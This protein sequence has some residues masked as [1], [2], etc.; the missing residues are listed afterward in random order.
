MAADEALAIVMKGYPRLSETFIA[1]ELL[2]LQ[3]SGLPFTIYALRKPTDA[4]VHAV[5]EAIKAPVRYLPEYLYQAPHRVISAWLQIRR[6]PELSDGYRRAWQAWLK[7][8]RRD[9]TPNRIRRFGQA[10]VLARELPRGTRHLYVHFLHTPASVTRYTALIRSLSW[11]C[12]AHAKDIYTVPAWEKAE[13]LAAMDWLVTCT[14]ANVTHLR[15]LAGADAGK[16]QL[17]YHGLDLERFRKPPV[18]P[19]RSEQNPRDGTDPKRPVR[20]L[21]VGRAVPKKGYDDLIEALHLLPPDLSWRLTHI[22][23]GALGSSLQATARKYGL[24]DKISWR[25]AQTQDQVLDAYRSADLFVLA[26]KIADDGDRDGLP[27]VLMEAQSQ[28]IACVSTNVSGVPE[29]IVD[30][31]TGCLVEPANPAALSRALEGLIRNPTRR[32]HL[33]D[34]GLLRVHTAFDHEAG[35]NRLVAR[36]RIH[37]TVPVAVEPS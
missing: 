10:M 28:G 19:S 35:V 12:S 6:Q 15:T 13:K 37:V 26:S 17:L 32:A 21:S 3:K 31:V 1:Q 27:N 23:G 2:S 29:L 7:D 14:A 16:V 22:G 8:F 30:E 36:L 20:L 11:S 34:A 5:H 33:G 25:G 24:A 4:R 18:A 9:P